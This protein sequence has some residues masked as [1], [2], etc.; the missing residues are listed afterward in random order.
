MKVL[1]YEELADIAAFLSEK[2]YNIEN[3]TILI[4]TGTNKMLQ[5]VNEDYFYRFSNPGN[6]E[7]PED[8]SEVK[9]NIGGTNFKYVS[10][11]EVS[12]N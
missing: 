7:T 2:G 6:G 10:S 11:E 4:D 5:R 9:V 3:L 12:E 8:V 1:K